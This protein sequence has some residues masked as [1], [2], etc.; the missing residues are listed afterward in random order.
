MSLVT[1]ANVSR[2]IGAGRIAF[3]ALMLV[4]PDRVGGS[5]LG[6]AGTTPA[7]QVALRAVG[8]RDAVI[9]MAQIH[10][11]GD[12][13]R[14]YRWARTASI[15]D[16]VDAA[17]TFAAAR[18]LPASGVAGTGVLAVGAAVAGVLTSRAMQRTA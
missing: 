7:A 14:G 8:I 6:E 16:A 9:G 15:G 5:W 4:A 13:D 12:P 3:G 2:F 10:T 11:A 17:A 1:P 18:S